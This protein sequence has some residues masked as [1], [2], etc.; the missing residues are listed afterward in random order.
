MDH[1]I[2]S[3]NDQQDGRKLHFENGR[4]YCSKDTERKFFF[5]L[6]IIMFLLGACFKLGVL[7]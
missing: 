7:Q 2:E 5:I 6:T 1:H 4:I 3:G